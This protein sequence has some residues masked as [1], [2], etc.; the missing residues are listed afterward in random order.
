MRLP[1]DLYALGLCEEVATR[2]TCDR[3]K[4]G[5]VLVRD[6]VIL[7]TG[8]NG[9]PRGLPHCDDIGHELDGDHCVR[10]THAE[11]NAIA[12]AARMGTAIDGCTLYCTHMPC[13]ACAKLLI[14]AG[15]KRLVAASD[16][17]ASERSKRLFLTSGLEYHLL[18]TVKLEEI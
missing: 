7:A 4:V 8:Y 9:S 11:A 3:L 6:K 12:Q 10:T 17:H 15:I 13:Y 14:N 2:G 18:A 1:F 5:A 16:Y